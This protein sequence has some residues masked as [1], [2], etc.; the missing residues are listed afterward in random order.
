MP[1]QGTSAFEARAAAAADRYAVRVMCTRFA[2]C[3][4][5][6]ATIEAGS[7]AGV[8]GEDDLAGEEGR[9]VRSGGD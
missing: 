4:A 1:A 8:A 2:D 7:R 5:V 3:A 9:I 6:A